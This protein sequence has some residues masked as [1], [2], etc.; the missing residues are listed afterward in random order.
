[1]ICQE[2]CKLFNDGNQQEVVWRKLIVRKLMSEDRKVSS[3]TLKLKGTRCQWWK[4][5]EE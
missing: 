5:V 1:M 2:S 4:R 3:V